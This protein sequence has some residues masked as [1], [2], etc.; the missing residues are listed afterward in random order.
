MIIQYAVIQFK[1]EVKLFLLGILD[2]W[3]ECGPVRLLGK[4]LMPTQTD[5]CVAN[6]R[7]SEASTEDVRELPQ[8][9]WQREMPYKVSCWSCS[10]KCCT[11]AQNCSVG[12]KYNCM[13]HH[14]QQQCCRTCVYPFGRAAPWKLQILILSQTPLIQPRSSFAS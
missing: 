6:V 14:S 4:I 2:F 9:N 7:A 12:T 10:F 5:V 3:C 1:T 13:N 8:C 11:T